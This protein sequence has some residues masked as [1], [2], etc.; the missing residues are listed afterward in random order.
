MFTMG[1]FPFQGKTHMVQPWIEPGTSCLVV[2][3]SD[4]QATRLVR[5]C[6]FYCFSTPTMARRRRLNVKL[7]VPYMLLQ[8]FNCHIRSNHFL[9]CIYQS[10]PEIRLNPSNS[11]RYKSRLSLKYG[12]TDRETSPTCCAS[13]FFNFVQELQEWSWYAHAQCL[14][15]KLNI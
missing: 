6:N 12:E 2:R 5:V 3:S 13:I 8:L 10:F 4:H 14:N 9:Y 7:C 15:N 11:L 1:V